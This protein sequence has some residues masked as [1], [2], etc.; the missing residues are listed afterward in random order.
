MIITGGENV[1]SIEVEDCLYQHPA[2]AEAA[3]IL[4]IA[5]MLARATSAVV[6]LAV[7]LLVA[8]PMVWSG[9]PGRRAR[10]RAAL[11]MLIRLLARL[12][13]HGDS[14]RAAAASNEYVTLVLW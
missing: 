12:P 6:M 10:S 13:G 4:V 8:C 9:N 7:V 1:S 2:V 5:Y 3:V 14:L 11:R